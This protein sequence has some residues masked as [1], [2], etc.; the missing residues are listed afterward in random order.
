MQIVSLF[1]GKNKK[2]IT[3]LLSAEFALKRWRF[4]RFVK[5]TVFGVF[6]VFFSLFFIDKNLSQVLLLPDCLSLLIK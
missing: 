4:K 3:D 5:Y 2:N 1:S 6:F